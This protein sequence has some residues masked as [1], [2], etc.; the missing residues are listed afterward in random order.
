MSDNLFDRQRAALARLSD[1]ARGRASA[2]A[3]LTAAFQTES[4]KGDREVA[5]ARKAHA[6]AIEKEVGALDIEHA[7][8]LERIAREFTT[9]QL[10]TDR[11][12]DDRRK[13]THARFSA[14]HQKG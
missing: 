1:A 6:A 14:A 11:T 7:A 3:G 10:A 5:R 4:E 9:E 8:A 2:E 12:R 13:Q